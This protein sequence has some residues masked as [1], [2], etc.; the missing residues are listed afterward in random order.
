MQ[1]TGDFRLKLAEGTPQFLMEIKMESSRFIICKNCTSMIDS[2]MD[3]YFED[4]FHPERKYCANCIRQDI[5]LRSESHEVVTNAGTR[6]GFKTEIDDIEVAKRGTLFVCAHCGKAH[7][8]RSFLETLCNS[9]NFLP[10]LVYQDS[11]KL[12]DRHRVRIELVR[13]VGLKDN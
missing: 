13:T 11:V 8:V 5:K 9:D 6:L 2:A 4:A 12:D 7:K 10:L 1:L 3:R